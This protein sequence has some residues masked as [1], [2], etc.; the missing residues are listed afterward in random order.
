[1]NSFFVQFAFLALPLLV[2]RLNRQLGRVGEPIALLCARVT[3][4]AGEVGRIFLE[5]QSRFSVH[6][7]DCSLRTGP[8]ECRPHF[9]AT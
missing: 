6:G 1:M 3:G 9:L 5:A 7:G 8:V 4:G 2:A